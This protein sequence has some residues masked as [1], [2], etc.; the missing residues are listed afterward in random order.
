MDKNQYVIDG[1]FYC[2]SVFGIQR[3]AREITEIFDADPDTAARFTVLVPEYCAGDITLKH[4]QVVRYG[5]HKGKLWRQIDLAGYLRK[6]HSQVLAFENIVP[7]FYRRGTVVLHDIIFRARPDFFLVHP[8]SILAISFWW[9]VY[10]RILH[11]SMKIV[12]VSSFCKSEMVKYYRVPED[13]IHVIGNGW[14]HM[15]RVISEEIPDSLLPDLSGRPFLFAIASAS[16]RHK[17]V[18]WFYRAA[19]SN[20]DLTFVISGSISEKDKIGCPSNVFLPGYLSDGQ[21]KTLFQRCSGF[22]FPSYYEGFG[23]PPLEAV[24][25][26]APRLI[27]SDI[28]VF[29]EVYGAYASY[30]D[31]NGAGEELPRL[32][33]APV[34]DFT[35]L[36]K[37]YSWKVSAEKLLKLL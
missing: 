1:S 2:G 33:D 26:G 34:R 10:S 13:R 8:R 20:P 6:H 31:P 16:T 37:K 7:L 15:Q 29:H 23:I 12:T 27:L 11:S 19:K 17:N 4:I 35:P 30:I 18:P 25:S 21:I 28:P 36:L 5:T 22:L 14:E 32:L 24:A 3:Y 9:F